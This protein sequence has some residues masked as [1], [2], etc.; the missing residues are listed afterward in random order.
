MAMS[1]FVFTLYH[2]QCHLLLPI[3]LLYIVQMLLER[4]I[5]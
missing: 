4:H 1:T 2:I 3:G 5:S